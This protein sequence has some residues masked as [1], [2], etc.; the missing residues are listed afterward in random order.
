MSPTIQIT[1]HQLSRKFR[2]PGIEQ[3]PKT[4]VVQAN[5]VEKFGEDI[6]HIATSMPKTHMEATKDLWNLYDQAQEN[7]VATGGTA[8]HKWA[9]TEFRRILF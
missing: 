8:V 7:I 1:P 5:L 2:F 9:L 3:H 6:E 4:F